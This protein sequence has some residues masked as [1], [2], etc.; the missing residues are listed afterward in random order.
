[1]MHI[2]IAPTSGFH[3]LLLQ[4]NVLADNNLDPSVLYLETKARKG[5]PEVIRFCQA[6]SKIKMANSSRM[7][8]SYIGV[9]A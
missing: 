4:N 2:S 6:G 9:A 5:S 7:P 1:M 3:L 8:A